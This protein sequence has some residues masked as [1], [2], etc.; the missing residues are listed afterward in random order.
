MR[1]IAI[2][3]VRSGGVLGYHGTKKAKQDESQQCSRARREELGTASESL[4]HLWSSVLLLEGG[5]GR[6]QMYTGCG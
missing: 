4:H 2:R 3:L 6:L 1:R 5:H